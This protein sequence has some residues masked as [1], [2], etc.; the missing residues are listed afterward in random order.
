MRVQPRLPADLDLDALS[1]TDRLYTRMGGILAHRPRL[2]SAFAEFGPVLAREAEL[3][4]RLRELV[5]LRIAFHNQCRSCMSIRYSSGRDAGVSEDLVCSLARPSES[6]DLSDAE[7][8]ALRFADLFATDHLAIDDEVFD[9]LRRHFDDGEIVEL[10]MVCAHYVASGRLMAVMRVTEDLPAAAR[11]DGP[12]APW[13]LDGTVEV[14]D[15]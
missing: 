4:A 7:K 15:V 12:V 8:A 14:R 1:P 6:P 9:A 5:R 3:P 10:A 13:A 11:A 2:A